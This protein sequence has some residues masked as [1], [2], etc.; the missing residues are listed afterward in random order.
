MTTISSEAIGAAP[1]QWTVRR[2]ADGD[3]LVSGEQ[4]AAE[5]QAE[6][7]GLGFLDLLDVVNPLQHLPV[8]G[9]IYRALTGDTISDAAR[10]AGGAL[11]GG[12]LGVI[13]ALAN[14]VVEAESGKDIG[15]NAM[16]W[17][18]TGPEAGAGDAGS[19]LAAKQPATA[20]EPVNAAPVTI[21]AAM[22]SPA[23]QA[24]QTAA[25]PQGVGPQGV[26]PQGIGPQASV[27]PAGAGAAQAPRD[28]SPEARPGKSEFQGRSAD[29][30]DAFI[31]QASAVRRNNPLAVGRGPASPAAAALAAA[32]PASPALGIPGAIDPARL[33]AAAL[34]P[35][36]TTVSAK[37][38][39]GG[40]NQAERGPAVAGAD[41]GSVNQW[42]LRALD[43]Y[44]HM[45]KQETS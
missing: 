44:E 35:P 7:S 20:A 3:E 45:R 25:T 33:Q 40:G 31:Q 38:A 11:Y 17:L 29:R 39:D 15:D 1:Q 2:T 43:K 6:T 4:L 16:A 41:T 32:N 24:A 42:M 30:L 23:A 10:M 5:R 26:G 37:S 18:G 21:A 12:P 27:L 19:A 34:K 13:G 28:L 22:A 9:T 14:V 8:V 36:A